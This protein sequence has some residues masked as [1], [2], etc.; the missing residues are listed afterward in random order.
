MS[1]RDHLRLGPDGKYVW[2]EN[3]E[4]SDSPDASSADVAS[5]AQTQEGSS[6]SDPAQGAVRMQAGEGRGQ[7]LTNISS[8]MS[9]PGI[10]DDVAAK[11]ASLLH[12]QGKPQIG[13][14]ESP[15][16]YDPWPKRK[17]YIKGAVGVVIVILIVIAIVLFLGTDYTIA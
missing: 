10:G 16:P 3:P 17:M 13:R 9:G 14:R 6:V 7:N 12:A 15:E 8:S 1:A 4:E 2:V 5:E 11:R